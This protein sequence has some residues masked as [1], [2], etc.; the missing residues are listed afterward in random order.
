[1][2]ELSKTFSPKEI[3]DKWY[4]QWINCGCFDRHINNL[5]KPFCVLMPPP[6]VTGVLH[7]GHLLNNT[8]Q[9]LLTRYARH[10]NRSA[11]WI[12]GTDHAGISMQ[13]R[14][15]KELNKQGILR[16]DIGREKFLEYAKKWRNEHGE[17]I[18]KQLRKLGV[19]CD[20]KNKKHTLD[21]DYS[22]GVTTAFVE[23]YNRGYIYRGKRMVNWCPISLTALS[24]EEVKMVP[25][26]SKLYYIKYLL[27]ESSIDYIEVATTRPETI[28]GDVAIAV[29]PTDER[30]KNLIGKHCRCPLFGQIIPI[31][32]DD[33]VIKDFGTGA[34]KITPAHDKVDFEIGQRHNLPIVNVLNPDGSLNKTAQEFQ[35][36]DRFD[37]RIKIAEKLA[38]NNLLTKE[39]EY[40][41]NIGFSERGNVPIEPKLSEQW[42]LHYPKIREA[43][44]AITEGIIEFYPK[45]WEKTYIHWLDNIQDWCISRQLW[46]G[47]RIPV[48]YKNNTDRNDPQN[49]HVSTDAPD[50][51]E[52]WEQEEDVLDT[53]FSSWLWPFGVFGWPNKDKMHDLGFDYFFPTDT[54][55]TGPDIIFFWVARMIIASLE[56]IDNEKK[57]LS[58]EEIYQRIPFHNVYFTGII[59]DSLGRKMSKSLGNSPE[60][61]DLIEK[62]GAD[63]LRLGLLLSAPYG[64]DILFDENKITLGRNFCN[65]LWNACRFRLINGLDYDKSSLQSIISHVKQLEPEDHAILLQLINFRA[66]I[67]THFSKYEITSAVQTAY[68]FFWNDYCDWYVEVSKQ[69]IQNGNNDVLLIHDIILRQ[70]LLILNPFIPFITEELWH[71]CGF[72]DVTTFIQDVYCETAE[73]L[74]N[75]LSV[76]KL[77]EAE[78]ENII[79]IR[80]FINICRTTIAQQKTKKSKKIKIIVQPNKDYNISSSTNIICRMLK[81]TS[82]TFTDHMLNLPATVTKFG[83]IYLDQQTEEST[84]TTEQILAEIEQLNRLIILNQKKLNNP[85]FMQKAPQNVINGAKKLLHEN[86]EKRQTLEKLL[87]QL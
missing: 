71:A 52:N 48:W 46:W 17:I 53:W 44:L 74:S 85:E 84:N 5:Q 11:I 69:R 72:G 30:Y 61:L 8:I 23:L 3:E 22:K 57:T 18:L 70:L 16:Q 38:K 40:L 79:N 28:M 2:N 24:D 80:E 19:S 60:P 39:E 86:I 50:D 14:V 35:G 59:R 10:N 36:L 65:K 54:L 82:F 1:M 49:W 37:A 81:I 25:Q 26:K 45:R 47:H 9:D 75:I 13:T 29:N 63:G 7:M 58:I 41:N 62:Y 67:N 34:L 4:N 78:L 21:E 64:Q 42:F 87:S 83:T 20:W 68:N 27:E 33:A 56:L 51:T 76:L 15:E 55:V 31:I 6:N 66:K 12:P 43:K 77:N 32:A 73:D